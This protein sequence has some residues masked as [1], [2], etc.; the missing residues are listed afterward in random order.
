[1]KILLL[2]QITC[3]KGTL[4]ENLAERYGFVGISIG[5][6]LRDE[7]QKDTEEAK[8]IAD[9]QKKGA[10]VPNDITLKV[11]K[12]YLSTVGDKNLIFDGYPRNLAQAEELDKITKLDAVFVLN[13]DDSIVMFRAMGRRNCKDCGSITHVEF[14]KG[15]NVCPKCGGEL[16]IR[17]DATKEATEKKMQ[18]YIKDTLPLIDY[19]TGKVPLYHIDANQNPMHTLEQVEKVLDQLK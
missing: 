4:S 12:N 7:T 13:V 2:G 17:A 14:L 5:Q 8:I 3:G 9:Y 16:E 15:S 1:M 6:L 18:S 11:L 19:Y 10:L